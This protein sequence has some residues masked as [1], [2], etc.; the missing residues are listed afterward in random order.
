MKRLTLFLYGIICCCLVYSQAIS[1]LHD[2]KKIVLQPLDSNYFVCVKNTDFMK[3]FIKSKDVRYSGDYSLNEIVLNKRDISYNDYLWA[4]VPATLFK[5]IET[6]PDVLYVSSNYT[7][8]IIGNDLLYSNLFLVKLKQQSDSVRL[9]ELAQQYD[10]NVV[11]NNEYMPLWYTL[12]STSLNTID[13]YNIFSASNEFESVEVDIMNGIKPTCTSDPYFSYQWNLSNT[14]QQGNQVGLDIDYC[15]AM[16]RTMGSSSVVV[17]VIDN[18]VKLNH[19]DLPNMYNYSYDSETNT[20]PSVL[21]GD[22]GTSCAGII[23]A[24]ANNNIGIAGIAPNCPIMSLSFNYTTTDL[25]QKMANCFNKAVLHNASVISCSWGCNSSN[26]ALSNAIMNAIRNGRNGLGC[27]VVFATGNE[28]C[29]I[30]YPANYND[31]ILAVGAMS[32]CGERKDNN[33]CDGEPWASN[34]GARL[35]V[36]APGVYI[37]TTDTNSNNYVYFSG[38]SAACPHV[39]AVAALVLSRNPNLTQME[40]CDIIEQTARIIR[41]DMYAYGYY[42]YRPNGLWNIEVGHGL[43]DAYAAVRQACTGTYTYQNHNVTSNTMILNCSLYVQNVT[44]SNNA[45]LTLMADQTITIDGPF[46][47]VSGS[48]LD[49]KNEY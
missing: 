35:D 13:L 11:G 34:Y 3:E 6:S 27:V 43:V 48:T 22:H 45:H 36:V 20:S 40:V 33:S 44:V 12:L 26:D 5:Q 39:A 15:H 8:N 18:G 37:P 49:V 31:S 46:E 47:V 23:G 1:Y 2:G 41:P 19:P 42:P 29:P 21:Y 38:T 14:G 16:L 24:A 7:S 30:S 25:Y 28:G 17:A 10:V 4:V 32:P 9:F